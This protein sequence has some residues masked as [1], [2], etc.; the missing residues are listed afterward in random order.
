[1]TNYKNMDEIIDRIQEMRGFFQIGGELI[2]F[3]TDLFV[4]LKDILPLMS[5]MKISMVDSTHKLPTAQDRI[6]DVSQ[7]TEMA[8]TEI[9]D[10]LDAISE[11]VN[12]ISTSNDGMKEEIQSAILDINYALQFQD[13]TSQKLEHANRI[14][15]AIYEKFQRLYT[16]LESLKQQSDVSSRILSSIGIENIEEKLSEDRKSFQNETKDIVRHESIS[17]DDIDDLFG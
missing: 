13:I 16:T 11:K 9:L 10:K 15:R 1:M 12:S 2:P 14:L 3:L 6:E 17:Q 5:E 8:T 4:F 7:A